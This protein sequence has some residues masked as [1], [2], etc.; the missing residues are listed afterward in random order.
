MQILTVK[1]IRCIS[2]AKQWELEDSG[3]ISKFLKYKSYVIF[4]S[5][6]LACSNNETALLLYLLHLFLEEER[7]Q[8]HCGKCRQAMLGQW[9][10]GR[11]NLVMRELVQLIHSKH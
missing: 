11:Y 8:L 2:K 10:V 4:N 7:L 3:I 5:S 9:V 1:Y 6:Y